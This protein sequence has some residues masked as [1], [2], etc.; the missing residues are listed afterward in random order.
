MKCIPFSI[1]ALLIA[2]HCLAETPHP[3]FFG[4]PGDDFSGWIDGRIH[5]DAAHYFEG[6]NRLDSG[7]DLRR[8]RL[9]VHAIL[10]RSWEAEID[11]N[12]AGDEVDVDDTWIA[13]RNKTKKIKVGAFKEPFGL[14]RLTSSRYLLFA[15]R[16]MAS[17]ALAP[18]RKIGLQISQAGTHWY[19]AAGFFGQEGDETA[20]GDDEAVALTGRFVYRPID[21]TERRLHLGLALPH[22]TPN[23]TASGSHQVRF[24][25]FP[26]TRVSNRRYLNTGRVSQVDYT[27][28]I[29]FEGGLTTGPLFLQGEYLYTAVRRGAGYSDLAVAGGYVAGASWRKI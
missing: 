6:K 1:A 8:V 24:R 23:A 12:L 19:A 9:G 27:E 4:A 2:V 3:L 11:I 22:R 20:A 10:Y 5:L 16:S 17:E 25:T 18:G 14:E 29:G 15:E 28:S 13:Y 26:E 7:T 21:E